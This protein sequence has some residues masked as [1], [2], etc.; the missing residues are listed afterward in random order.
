MNRGIK[1]RSF[2]KDVG[3]SASALCVG[4][5][6]VSC[7]EPPE[8]EG[9]IQLFKPNVNDVAAGIEMNPY[10]YIEPSG[11]ITIFA[12]KPEMGQGTFQ[13][14]P[15]LIAEELGV[16]LSQVEI[17]LA[18]ADIAF[19]EQS[20][21]GSSSVRTMWE[22]MRKI[23]A[24]AR[25]MLTEVAAKRWGISPEEC[26]AENG[27]IYRGSSDDFYS[28]G[29]L[30]EEAILLDVPQNPRLKEASKFKLIGKKTARPDIPLKVTGQANFGIDMKLEGM[31]YASIERSP[32]FT[33]KVKNIIDQDALAIPGVLEVVKSIRPVGVHN[34]EGVAVIADNYWAAEQGRRALQ[35]EWEEPDGLHSS[36]DLFQSMRQKVTEEG[37]IYKSE[38][39]FEK[40]FGT[41]ENTLVADYETP[42]VAHSP[43]EPM[44][45]LA[46]VTANACE[47]WTAVQ[48]PDWIRSEAAEM[49]DFE[50]SQVTVHCPFM[51]GSFGRKGM[52]D[53][54]LEGVLLSKQ[55]GKPVKI[56]W[57]RE[58][59]VQQGPFR[60]GSMNRLSAA[61]DD[62]GKL[63][64]FQHKVSA[65]SFRHSL[66]D[67]DMV[68]K[69]NP[70]WIM[71][72]IGE[73]FYDSGHFSSNYI[74]MD[75]SPIP[76]MW[77]RSVY[78]STNAFG[79]EC[80]VDELAHETQQDPVEFRLAH[81]TKKPKYKRFLSFLAEKAGWSNQL[82][83]GWSRGIAITHCFESTTGQ[84]IEVSRQ[85][86][87]IKIERVVTAIDCGIA[88][89]P[90]N[91]VAQCEGCVVMGLTAAIKDGLTFDKG[92]V[93]ESN[94]HDH[95]VLRMSEIPKMETFIFPS[96][97]AP[98]GTGEPALPTVAPAL[99]NAIF[100]LTG[101]RIRKLPI[102]L[103]RV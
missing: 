102:D 74:W 2:L 73:P 7:L 54:S 87:K 63:M 34:W 49:L 98:T 40:V 48:F 93:K 89:N 29:Q 60:P 28:F 64:A 5:H 62:E 50:E 39:N 44:N 85:N 86:Q 47:L 55:L 69:I 30:V 84:V 88:I 13:S 92:R 14:I 59:D 41:A 77:W 36:E 91:V 15:M 76:V 38:G 4:Y 61:W 96:A 65:P 46:N 3:I 99:A 6:F 97:E 80:F 95:R 37:L 20:V 100:N 26:F 19:E 90:T 66:W 52:P 22:P 72:P 56:V 25:E 94:F 57:T 17:K 70:P 8:P 24:S 79:Q 16:D 82:P 81:L 23:G 18:Q 51:G 45:T 83:T 58:D 11:E 103:G 53:F 27:N 68:G 9:I 75:I 33:G 101:K 21:G 42:F 1:R 10:L 67:V 43:M 12:H 32:C 78:S 71:E 31:V 35:I